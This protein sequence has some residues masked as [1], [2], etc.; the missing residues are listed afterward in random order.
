MGSS[1]VS[2]LG[3]R[4]VTPLLAD[5]WEQ[6]L[7]AA[8]VLLD[9]LSVLA[10]LRDGFDV[11]L[12]R[13]AA[14]APF[15]EDVHFVLYDNHKSAVA[16]P[17]VIE[18]MIREEQAAGRISA[19]FEPETLFGL[20]GHFRNAP[21]TIAAKDGRNDIG[22]V[23][24]DFSHPR[25]DPDDPSFNSLVDLEAF[26]CDWGTFSQCCLLAARAPPGS[27]VAVFDVQAAHRRVPILPW[28]QA[29]YTIYWNG[30]VALNLC[31]QFGAASSSGLWG[32]IADAFCAIFVHHHPD[33]SVLNWADDFTFWRY[34]DPFGR[35]TLS[36]DDIECL[37]AR[38]GL[39]WSAKK[40]AP[41]S[42]TFTYLGFAWDL[43]RRWVQLTDKKR[44]K[45]VAALSGWSVGTGVT[46]SEVAKV[47]GKLMHCTLVVRDGRSRLASL[48]RFCGAFSDKNPWM[49]FKLP[50]NVVEDI[51]WWRG[52]LERGQCGMC[53]QSIPEPIPTSC[54]VDASS[55][56]GIGLVIDGTWCAW[57]LGL[58]W[59]TDGRDIGWAEMVAVEMGILALVELG[60]RDCH[61][62]LHSDNKGVVGAL[63]SG[64]SRSSQ[65]N[66]V[67]QRI[68]A[69]LLENNL[70]VSFVWVRS[71]DNIADAPSR[72]LSGPG[73]CTRL[74]FRTSCAR[75]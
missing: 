61:L 46:R 60:Y 47:L 2:V 28:Q 63:D 30:K 23:C 34:P 67:L 13:E 17:N 57:R 62:E 42:S 26:T 45:Y 37:A 39:P 32:R 18:D 64:R 75:F 33:A 50:H 58:N 20:V 21:L 3:P 70:W 51:S 48:G 5:V 38:L 31:C 9:F 72:G 24:Q 73:V 55:A 25:N 16:F 36:L 7:V 1:A 29:F 12:S 43:D 49:R 22:R 41:F 11:G 4:I 65:C 74:E 8:G 40:T 15:S 14:L 59:K 71:E 54:F 69:C 10:G 6:E 52:R 56:F 35:F 68:V 53:I 27:E 44:C 19:F 66:R